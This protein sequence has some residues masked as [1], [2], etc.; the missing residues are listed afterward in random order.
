MSRVLGQFNLLPEALRLATGVHYWAYLNMRMWPELIVVARQRLERDPSNRNSQLFLANALHL[1]GDIDQAQVLYE[2]V[3]SRHPHPLIIDTTSETIA[4]TA[5]A[6]LGRRKSGDEAGALKLIELTTEDLRQRNRAGLVHGEYYRAAAIIAALEGD[7]GSALENIEK[8]IE[9][10]PRDPS[11]FSEPAVEALR[12][13]P[14]FKV[15][16]SRADS[17]LAAQRVK[18]LHMM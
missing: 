6:A 4:A 12:D 16:E 1:S 10:G 3:L 9:R 14:E 8:A 2:G 5:R 7:K 18:A 11:L 17:I 15:L 13:S